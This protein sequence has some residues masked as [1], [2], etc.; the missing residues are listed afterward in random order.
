MVLAGLVFVAREGPAEYGLDAEDVEIVRRDH[1]GTQLHG[2]AVA[3]QGGRVAGLRGHVVEDRVVLLPVEVIERRD[4][5]PAA[6]RRL[7][8]YAHDP[9]G[10]GVRKRLQQHAIHETEDGGIRA[11]A[12]C[13]GGNRDG[14]EPGALPEGPQTEAKVLEE[15][16]HACA[17]LRRRVRKLDEADAEMFLASLR[18]DLLGATT[19]GHVY[20][21]CAAPEGLRAQRV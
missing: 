3:G 7:F 14:G 17:L 15:F 12:D 4:A 2:F 13:Q 8:E 1:S 5:V 6:P 10:F 11:N 20:A 9:V 18:G 19:R 21:G 16:V